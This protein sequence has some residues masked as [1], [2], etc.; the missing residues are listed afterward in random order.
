MSAPRKISFARLHEAFQ[1]PGIKGLSNLGKT[2][3]QTDQPGI[4]MFWTGDGLECSY[5]GENFV[6]P[7]ANVAGVT[8]EKSS[9]ALKAAS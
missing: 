8:I 4:I 3:S 6:V 9:P 5:K 2:L 7:A 1:Q